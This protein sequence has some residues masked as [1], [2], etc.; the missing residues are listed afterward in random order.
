MSQANPRLSLI[1][2]TRERAETLRYALKTAVEQKSDAIEIIVSDNFSKDNTREIVQSYDDPRVRYVNTGQPMSM[3]GNFEFAL[4][5]AR[6]EYILFIG[7]DDAVLPGG[8]DKLLA[9]MDAHPSPIYSWPMPAY[10]WPLKDKKAYTTYI[11]TPTEPHDIDLK[12]LAR[13][14]VKHGGWQYYRIPCVYQ[15]AVHRSITDAIRAKAGKVFPATQPDVFTSMAI[16]AF[17]DR[18]RNIGYSITSLGYCPKANGISLVSGSGPSNLERWYREF[19]DYKLHP[20]LCLE[21]NYIVQVITD[22]ILIA[23][24]RFPEFYGGMKF[25]YEAAWAFNYRLYGK[26]CDRRELLRKR[27]L[28][29]QHHPF[30]AMKFLAYCAMHDIIA[31][32]QEMR[33]QRYIRESLVAGTPDNIRDFVHQLARKEQTPDT[34]SFSLR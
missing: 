8:L 32:R 6:G 13:F 26:L 3:C 7:D 25:N 24:E 18:A 15:A 33:K 21:L 22:A 29:Q 16:P 1:I 28:V 11:P 4:E 14:V 31:R 27:K 17:A 10:Y 2:P 12:K 30:N 9:E 34:P 23:M 19:G 20:T 5:Q